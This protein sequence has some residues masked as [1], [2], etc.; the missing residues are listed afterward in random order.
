[1]NRALVIMNALRLSLPLIY[2]LNIWTTEYAAGCDD[3]QVEVNGRCCNPCPPGEYLKEMCSEHRP[4]VCSP[5][6]EGHFSD[7]V[8]RWSYKIKH[9]YLQSCGLNSCFSTEYAEKCTPTTNANCS[10]RHGFLCSSNIC[11]SCVENKCVTGERLKRTGDI[12]C[13]DIFNYERNKLGQLFVL[14]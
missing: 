4:T 1:M 11:S 10:C 2:A 6:A 7:H 3:G 9:C 13:G 12:F 14:K 8:T 5:C